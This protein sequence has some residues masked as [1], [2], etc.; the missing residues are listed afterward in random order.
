[1]KTLIA[2]LTRPPP[3]LSRRWWALPIRAIVGFGFTEHGYAKLAHGPDRRPRILLG[4]FMPLV[5]ER[6][7]EET[8]D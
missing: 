6:S 7:R 3:S 8:A 5:T 1:V 4:A 2:L